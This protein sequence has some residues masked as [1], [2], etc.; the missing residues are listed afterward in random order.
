[1]SGKV[2]RCDNIQGDMSG[3]VSRDD[4]I[5]GDMSGKVSG[6]TIYRGICLEN[7]QI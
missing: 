1:M 4:N 2:S 3:K 7:V 5:Q 6:M